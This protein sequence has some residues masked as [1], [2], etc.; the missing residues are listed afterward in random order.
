MLL[1]ARRLVFSIL[2]NAIV[3]AKIVH[4]Y[5]NAHS[6]SLAAFLVCL[7][8]FLTPDVLV[9]LLV[10]SLLQNR[11]GRCSLLSTVASCLVSISTCFAAAALVSFFCE[12]GGE[13]RWAD[14]VS[15]A[16]DAGARKVASSGSGNAL[17]ACTAIIV[18]SFFIQDLLH[19]AVGAVLHHARDQLDS[20]AADHPDIT[21]PLPDLVTRLKWESPDGYF[22]GWAPG[23]D[24]EFVSKYRSRVPEWLPES[25][26][27]G[28]HRWEP[29]SKPTSGNTSDN[30]TNDEHA[31]S[32]D[33]ASDNQH[34]YNPVNDPLK[35]NNLHGNI[36]PAL[37]NTLG[38]ESVNI[39]HVVLI[40][41]ESMRQ[42]LFPLQ[43]DS[44]F[45]KM[46]LQSHDESKYDDVNLQLARLTVNSERVTG[47]SGDF[48]TADGRRIP[49]ESKE[50]HD[51]TEAG[52]G[53]LNVIGTHT[54]C[55]SSIK[56]LAAIHCG[57]WPMPVDWCEES[58]LQSYQ[59][60]LP[61][62]FKLLNMLKNETPNTSDYRDHKWY[63]AFFQSIDDE[64]DDQN[65][66]DEMI[67]FEHIVTR[68]QVDDQVANSGVDEEEVN[69]FGYAE[70]AIKSHIKDYMKKAIESNQRMFL[71][72]FT[73]TTHH[74]WSVPSWFD[75][76]EYM[77]SAR[78][79]LTTSHEDMNN[80]LNTIRWNDAWVGEVMQL[81]DDFG[82][83]NETLVVFVGDH[84]QA[85]REDTKASGTYQNGHIS[86]F[87]VPLAF[88]H[89]RIPRVQLTV[90][91]TSINILPTVLDLLI[92]S[93]S[94]NARDTDA[95]S[96]IIQ[97]YEG[98][99]LIRPFETTHRGRRAWNFG[100]VNP[101]GRFLA[102]TSADVPWRLVLPWDDSAEYVFTNL[103][104][105]P[106]ELDGI[107][108]WS[109]EGLV[110]DVERHL[111]TD[112][113]TWVREAASVARW[114]GME[115]KRLWKYH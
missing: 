52:L 97:D 18:V 86:N 40:Q 28:F 10:W 41:M 73:S 38:L 36:L 32:P 76:T 7:P 5:V 12:T 100:I 55:S 69:Y 29:Q 75:K 8:V 43:K 112:A 95:A 11:R 9:L 70:T 65:N 98:Q 110:S 34:F 48:H 31:E 87:R 105:D 3:L 84:G 20:R 22:K 90:N 91:S 50:W 59:P 67:G 49:P 104:K 45:H 51:R 57:V 96:D 115:R 62:I 54:T 35:I 99:S 88:R 101:G 58:K 78:G 27:S 108:N 60:C 85:F 21:W 44:N 63:P 72:H 25:P 82:I 61:Q 83:S 42:E 17:I 79:G 37:R 6:F 89:P 47:V 16:F 114:W 81:L 74:P 80:Y 56:S 15:V 103:E 113:A 2:F 14:A 102:M 93:G 64:F 106:L 71:S 4:L 66:M 13:I 53:G 39:R 26:P 46:V 94:L 77:G 19:R 111:G 1:A 23:T 107:L 30:A 33:S 24:N 68:Q 109:L 92:S